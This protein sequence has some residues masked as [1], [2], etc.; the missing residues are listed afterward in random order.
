MAPLDGYLRSQRLAQEA[1]VYVARGLEAGSTEIEAAARIERYLRDRGV[2]SF[3][4]RPFA[5]FGDRSRFAGF[6]GLTEFLPTAR[7]LAAGEPFI[8]DVAPV[9]GGFVSD[10]GYAHRQGEREGAGGH[11]DLDR[12]RAFLR[13]LRDEIPGMFES[14]LKPGEIWDEIDARIR[15]AGFENCHGKYPFSVLAHRVYQLDPSPMDRVLSAIVPLGLMSWFSLRAQ[16][17]F[18]RRG[19]FH[20]LIRPGSKWLNPRK[21][22]GLWAVEPH[23]GVAPGGVGS[24]ENTGGFGAKFEEILVVGDDGRARWLDGRPPLGL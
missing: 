7:R 4:H 18:A 6:R 24:A 2:M 19:L 15:G 22:R 11:A 5:W 8:L 23:I 14:T 17:A 16:W 10:I 9:V 1:A 21:K 13:K 3:F 20:E 12:A